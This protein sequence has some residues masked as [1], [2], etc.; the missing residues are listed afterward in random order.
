MRLAR[1]AGMSPAAAEMSVADRRQVQ[2]ALQ[3]LDYYRRPVDGIF[4]SLT[5]A[6]IR[7]IQNI[8]AAATGQLRADQ[9]N[10]LVTPR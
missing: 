5:R 7:R 9:A 2:E 4:G 8:P 1:C 3:R 6:A 10:R